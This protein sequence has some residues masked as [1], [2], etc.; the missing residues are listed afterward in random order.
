[1]WI[2]LTPC[3][4]WAAHA[5][6]KMGPVDEVSRGAGRR[7]DYPWH[8]WAD[9]SVWKVVW[10]EDYFVSDKAFRAGAYAQ[11]KSHGLSVTTRSFEGGLTI[12]FARQRRI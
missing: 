11:A 7:P 9:G 5:W 6:S 10:G 8:R 4:A 3:A 12:Q 1:M 2:R